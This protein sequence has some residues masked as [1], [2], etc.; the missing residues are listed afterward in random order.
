[1]KKDYF[2]N[3]TALKVSQDEN[4]KYQLKVKDEYLEKVAFFAAEKDLKK[5]ELETLAYIAYHEPVN[6]STIIQKVRSSSYDYI[7]TLKT[8]GF[9]SKEI[10][11][12]ERSPILKTTKKF[13]DY[14]GTD[15]IALKEMIKEKPPENSTLE[16]YNQE[17]EQTK[18]ENNSLE[19]ENSTLETN[20]NT[21]QT[22]STP[23]TEEKENLPEKTQNT[24]NNI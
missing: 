10:I 17:P 8:H 15:A 22:D 6:Q 21:T 16:E 2:S 9:I 7:K 24:E 11:D 20:N 5:R 3:N 4:G 19:T 1:L 23:S 12:G 18:N 13:R 14:F